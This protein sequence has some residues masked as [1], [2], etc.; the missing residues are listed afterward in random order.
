[1]ASLK[2]EPL[3]GAALAADEAERRASPELSAGY[4]EESRRWEVIVRYSGSLSELEAADPQISVT[5]LLGGYALIR[6]PEA[7]MDVLAALPQ[8]T[9]IEKPKRLFFEADNAR[10][11]SCVTSLQSEAPGSFT[12]RGILI[13]MIDSGIDYTHPDFIDPSGSS[14]IL[15]LWDQT[16]PPEPEAGHLP[17]DGYTLGTLYTKE[18]LNQ[19]LSLANP[20]ELVPSIDL[21]G[22]G[23]HVAGIAGGNGRASQGQFRGVAYEADYLIVKLGTP[24]PDGFPGTGQLMQAV[25]FC[26]RFSIARNLPLAINLSFG[27]TYGSHSGTSLLETYLDYVSQLGRISIIAGSGNE[28]STSGH[29]AA[30]LRT[31]ESARTEFAVSDFQTNLSIQ[32]WSYYWDEFRF[33]IFSPAGSRI[34]LPE[35]PGAWRFTL[36]GTRL[37]IYIG[38]PAPYSVFREIYID[39]IPRNTYLTAGVWS[40]LATAGR[41][42]NGTLELWMPVGSVRGFATQ[43]LRPSTDMTL[44]IPSTASRVISVGAYDS[45]RLQ[46]AGFSGRGYTWGSRQVKPELVAPGVNITSCAPGGGYTTRSGTSMAAPFVTGGCAAL[47]QWGILAG[48]NPYLYGDKLKA[49]LIK[50]TNQLSILSSYPNPEIGWGVFCLRNSLPL[51]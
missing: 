51:L 10:S 22:H 23:T 28:G 40:L 24:D 11:D 33:A 17:P 47:M 50:G 39:F 26:V 3:L 13:A 16:I 35:E 48:N 18:Q 2:M 41:V 5:E 31:G 21:S 20:L 12:G 32:L 15:A 46:P 19:A 45:S 43:F 9:Y 49:Y 36:E 38:E 42:S 27:N 44:T 30:T 25:D 1:M 37:F 6:L 8:I 14:R 29:A 34:V 7:F 4:S